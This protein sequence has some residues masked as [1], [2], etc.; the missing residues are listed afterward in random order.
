[1]I[2]DGRVKKDGRNYLYL[3]GRGYLPFTSIQPTTSPPD[4]LNL[5]WREFLLFYRRLSV[6]TYLLSIGYR[7]NNALYS[8][9]KRVSI[10]CLVGTWGTE[11]LLSHMVHE[12]VLC[13]S[14]V[15]S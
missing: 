1:M 12:G 10:S 7:I 8:P 9:L 3:P 5:V 15:H 11:S 2:Q 14:L 13:S 4:E 6:R